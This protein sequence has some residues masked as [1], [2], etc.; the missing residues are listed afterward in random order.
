M[1]CKTQRILS[2]NLLNYNILL[3][4]NSCY[5]NLGNFLKIDK[6]QIKFNRR[7]LLTL[8]GK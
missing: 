6:K 5:I 1:Y 2:F 8:K 7:S 3:K 4:A